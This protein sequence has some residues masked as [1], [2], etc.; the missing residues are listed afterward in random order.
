MGCSA[1][2]LTTSPTV[3]VTSSNKAQVD[4]CSNIAVQHNVGLDVGLVLGGAT[5]GLS[6]AG[7]LTP[8]SNDSLK[9]GLLLTGVIVGA[10]TL[11]D[12]GFV[13]LTASNFASNRCTD[14]VEPL[15]MAQKPTALDTTTVEVVK[16][17]TP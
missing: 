17:E 1:F 3:P 8:S 16:K 10:L 9:N 6:S 5:T 14:V 11:V 15:P 2:T 12:T 13:G 4:T 7:A